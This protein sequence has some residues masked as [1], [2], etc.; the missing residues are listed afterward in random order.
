MPARNRS[1]QD[2][3]L[4]RLAN[5]EVASNYLNE[6]LEE[7]ID[8]F[9]VALKTVAQARQM[10]KVAREAGVQRETLYRS[11]S[12]QGNPTVDTLSSILKAVG[13]K[14]LVGTNEVDE[15]TAPVRSAPAPAITA[16]T[17]TIEDTSG[18]DVFYSGSYVTSASN[19]KGLW[20]GTATPRQN[21]DPQI[22]I[23]VG[24][25]FYSHIFTAH[26]ENERWVSLA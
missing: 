14:L 13:L 3:L 18:D 8:S 23:P 24:T 2:L 4:E 7:S 6:A 22:D 9:L 5:P 10:A 16:S 1:F 26:Q 20:L 21:I 15:Q 17:I 12:E 19:A 25:R 11:L